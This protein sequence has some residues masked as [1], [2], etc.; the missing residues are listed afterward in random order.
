[1]RNPNAI[2]Y[3]F[4]SRKMDDKFWEVEITN[5]FGRKWTSHATI[6]PNMV[7]DGELAAFA[8]ALF[9]IQPGKGNFFAFYTVNSATSDAIN[10]GLNE[11]FPRGKPSPECPES[12]SDVE[13]RFY[14][15]FRTR[16]RS[17]RRYAYCQDVVDVPDGVELPYARQDAFLENLR[18]SKKDN[19]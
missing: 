12:M 13:K 5:H 7:A 8:A 17:N 15:A 18:N 16:L 9:S 6:N 19:F 2:S 14:I 11:W 10:Y 3:K 4:V 1:M